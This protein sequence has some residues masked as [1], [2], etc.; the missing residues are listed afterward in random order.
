MVV[1]TDAS[2]ADRVAAAVVVVRR[3]IGAVLAAILVLFGL[4][5]GRIVVLWRECRI[6]SVD[7]TISTI[8]TRL[9]KSSIIF[10]LKTSDMWRKKEFLSEI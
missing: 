5:V 8:G 7:P 6:G 9:N 10:S 1:L 3:S 2:P 4:A